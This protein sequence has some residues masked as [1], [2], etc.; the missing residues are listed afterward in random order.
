M[1]KWKIWGVLEVFRILIGVM[2]TW[3]CTFDKHIEFVN[4]KQVLCIACKSQFSGV[5]Q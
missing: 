1:A 2:I 4:L 3:E 5:N